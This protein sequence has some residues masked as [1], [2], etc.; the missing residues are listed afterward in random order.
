MDRLGTDRGDDAVVAAFDDHVGAH[1]QNHFERVGFAEDHQGVDGSQRGVGLGL[2][3]AEDLRDLHAAFQKMLEAF[4]AHVDGFY[5]CPHDRGQCN[6]RKPLPGLFEQAVADFP[7]ITA[8]SSV[9]IGDS[10]SDI[11]FGRRLGMITAFIDG[12]PGATETRR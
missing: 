5:F 10:K 9:L 3:T 2:Y 4:G 11:E 6:C 8:T 12:D 7:G 1:N